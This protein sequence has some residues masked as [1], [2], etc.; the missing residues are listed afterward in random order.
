M[1]AGIDVVVNRT[2]S[3][4][5]ADAG[6][7]RVIASAAEAGGARLHETHDLGD[8][9]EVAREI[10][11]RGSDGV[12]LAGGDGSHMAGLTALA[13]AFATR[14]LPPIALAPGGTV[15]TVARNLGMRGRASVCAERIVRAACEGT[16]RVHRRPT[17]RVR[18]DGGGDRVGFI[19]GAGLVVRFFEAYYAAPRQG[20]RTAASLV[21][22]IFAGS[23][24]GG[25]LAAAVLEP[26]RCSLRVDGEPHPARGWSLVLASVVRDVG[27]HLLV[28]YRAG[29]EL[30]RFHLVAS[31]LAVRA[32]AEQLPRVLVGRPLVGEPR[33]DSLARSLRIA[34]EGVDGGYVLDGDVFWARAATVEAG[35][36]LSMLAL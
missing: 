21:A 20:S 30:E 4:L 14:A 1:S 29:E 13:R 26:A 32:L 18:D 34:F 2:A 15:C 22:R 19:F 6:L 23:F 9:E 24:T 28:P 31:G 8:L 11:A 7:R 33:I 10:A 36:V 12:V 17:L 5:R 25:R 27:L 35:P 16:A 3:R